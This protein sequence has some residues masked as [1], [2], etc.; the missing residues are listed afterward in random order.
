MMR[1]YI[2]YIIAGV[3]IVF[4]LFLNPFLR[5]KLDKP[6]YYIRDASL[7]VNAQRELK[8][9]TVIKIYERTIYKRS[10]PQVIYVDRVDSNFARK[11]QQMDLIMR[12]EKRHNTLKLTALNQRDS[13]VKEF[14]FNDVPE[15]FV[16]TSMEGDVFVKSTN[17][18]WEGL[19]VG[20]ETG[21]NLLNRE[22][23][24]TNLNLSTEFRAFNKLGIGSFVKYWVTGEN[25]NQTEIGLTLNYIIK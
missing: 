8:N 3:I 19:K 5:R 23:L 16:V 25:L 1:N 18:I 4:L 10:K 20:I 9:D 12:L 11:L 15:N 24:K 6:T 14:R 22:K 17:F 21:S 13:L 7:N 2:K